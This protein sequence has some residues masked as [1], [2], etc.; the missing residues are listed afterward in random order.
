LDQ[1]LTILYCSRGFYWI[2]SELR[3]VC[4]LFF[5]VWR[6]VPHEWVI[7]WTRDWEESGYLFVLWSRRQVIHCMIP[8]TKSSVILSQLV[9][10][11][12]RNTTLCSTTPTSFVSQTAT[13]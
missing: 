5:L 4:F 3:R 7:T 6:V 12:F 9:F 11:V 1:L 8:D 10:K 2:R 13:M